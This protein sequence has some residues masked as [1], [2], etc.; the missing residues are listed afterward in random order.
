MEKNRFF[1][2][3]RLEY[4]LKIIIYNRNHPQ[5]TSAFIIIIYHR[6]HP[7]VKAG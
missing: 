6:N 2:N 4:P 3:S 7:L 5:L 1:Q